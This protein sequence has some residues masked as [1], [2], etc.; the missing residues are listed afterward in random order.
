M[1]LARDQQ[2]IRQTVLKT[3]AKIRDE[4]VFRQTILKASANV[5]D[6]QVFRQTILLRGDANIGLICFTAT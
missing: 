3:T 5:R 1:A 2:I 6:L 4:Q